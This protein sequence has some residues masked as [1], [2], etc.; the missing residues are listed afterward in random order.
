[1][2]TKYTILKIALPILFIMAVTGLRAQSHAKAEEYMNKYEFVEAIESYQQH[3]ATHPATPKEIRNITYCYMQVNDTKLAEKWLEKL[4]NS[5]DATAEDVLIYANL[6]KSEGKYTEAIVQYEKYKTLNPSDAAL[7]EKEI[8]SSSDAITWSNETT[9]FVVKNEDKFNSDKSDFGL[10]AYGD[11]FYLTSD[12]VSKQVPVGENNVYGWTG[13]PYL[14]LYE[15]RMDKTEVK[16][17]DFIKE[18]NDQFHS[19]PGVFADNNQRIYFT[20]TKTVKQ[21]QKTTNPDPTS[22]FKDYSNEIYTN[23]LE[24]YSADFADGKWEDVDAF[25]NNNPNLYSIGHPA[26]SPDGKILYFVSDMVG[27]FGQTDIYY[28]EKRSNGTWGNPRNAGPEINTSGKELF[29]FIDKNGNMYFSSDGHPGMGGLDLFKSSGSTNNWS[30]PVNLKSPLN[31]YKDDFSIFVIETDSIG[32]FSSNRY[33]GIGSDDIYSFVYVPAPPPVPTQLILAVTTYER[34]ENGTIVPLA[35]VDVHYHTNVE[36]NPFSIAQ[37]SPGVYYATVDCDT[38]F[39]VNG[40]KTGY[41]STEQ[42]VETKCKTM[43]DTAFV[44]LIL[45]KI[46]LNKPILI[47]NI[48]YDY[49]K[50]NIRPDAAVELEKIVELLVENPQIIIELGSHTDC[51]GNDKYNE[52]LSQKRA[53]SAV[54]YIIGRGI[55]KDRITAKGYGEKILVNKCDDG[56]QCSEEEHQMN[57]R[58]EFKVIGFNKDQ[59]VIYSGQE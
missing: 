16:E 6:L 43:N 18:L 52:D 47:E 3:F 29:P 21:I 5:S 39:L 23:R 8:K 33:G 38:K 15:V 27:G 51:R 53:V 49:D 14:K 4:V 36:G 25:E 37:F 44:Q 11:N 1:M 41:F 46:V 31:S 12:R 59:P 22:W 58:T 48:Y 7:A 20:R 17:I 19:G 57:R 42:E 2:K 13:N 35:D 56:V 26:I 45:E 32:Y 9:Y 50:W 54:D 24:I 30:T 34:L 40:A 55:S 10:I 28:S